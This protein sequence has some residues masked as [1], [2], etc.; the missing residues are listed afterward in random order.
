MR[1]NSRVGATRWI[2][3]IAGLHSESV[4]QDVDIPL[5]RAGEFFEFYAR[6]IGLWPQWV[7]PIGPRRA[8][9]A[10]RCTRCG[11]TGTSISGSGT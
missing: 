10:S 5:A 3:R 1:W 2:E 11:R 4:I 8:R 6:E 7:C 9:G